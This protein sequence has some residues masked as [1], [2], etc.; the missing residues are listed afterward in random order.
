M[1]AVE[2]KVARGSSVSPALAGLSAPD[3]AQMDV[4]FVDPVDLAATPD[5]SAS[6]VADGWE[7]GALAVLLSAGVTTVT[8]IDEQRVARVRAVLD[9]LEA[10][11]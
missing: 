5:P 1:E 10:A 11:R 3:E 8:G 4:A 2:I 9:A 6:D 7:I